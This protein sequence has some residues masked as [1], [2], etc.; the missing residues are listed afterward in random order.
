MVTCPL[1]SERKAKRACP[2]LVRTICPVC[3]ATK[4]LV[5]VACPPDCGYLASAREH[6]AAVVRRQQAADAARLIPTLRGFTER[7][8][9]LFFLFQTV[10]ARHSPEPPLRL[11]DA[12]VADAS[13]SLAATLETASR[14]LIYEHRSASSIA[15]RLGAELS[16]VLDEIKRQRGAVYDSEAALVLRA[17]E[18]GARE[19]GAGEETA[20]LQLMARLLHHAPRKAEA[21]ASPLVLP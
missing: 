16:G 5:E 14:G 4:R 15:A 19:V 21:P 8:Y 7:Q 20:Y 10:I 11:T 12:D 17:I 13:A 9:Q 3:C 18:R 6:P 1:C 2:A